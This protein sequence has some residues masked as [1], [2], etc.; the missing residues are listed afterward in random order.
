MTS[1]SCVHFLIALKIMFTPHLG[2]VKQIISQIFFTV[3]TERGFSSSNYMG[4]VFMIMGNLG[5]E[6]QRIQ[7]EVLGHSLVR[8]LI[9]LHRSLVHSALLASLARSAVLTCSF[10]HFAH[11]LAC[12]TVN[13]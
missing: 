5:P 9:C 8:L 11:S 4:Y 2:P 7:T 12:G 6:Q 1:L 10:T 3:I 13:D